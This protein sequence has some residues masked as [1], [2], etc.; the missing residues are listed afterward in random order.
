MTP[1]ND[2]C[3]FGKSFSK[4]IYCYSLIERKIGQRF[5]SPPEG[6]VSDNGLCLNA[7]FVKGKAFAEAIFPLISPSVRWQ[8]LTVRPRKSQMNV[9]FR[10]F[11]PIDGFQSLNHVQD[12][13]RRNISKSSACEAPKLTQLTCP[14]NAS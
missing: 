5:D 6:R 1:R 3:P 10:K 12:A 2:S 7:N 9:P 4:E 14:K 8:H 11:R 13:Y